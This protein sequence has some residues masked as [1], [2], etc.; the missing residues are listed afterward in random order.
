MPRKAKDISGMRFNHLTALYREENKDSWVC[1]CDCGN[2]THTTLWKLEHDRIKS[3][4]CMQNESKTM[5]LEGNR[6]GRLIVI[7]NQD[8]LNHQNCICKCDCG[9]IK[10][11][12][13][14]SVKNGKT[15]SCGCL[16]SEETSQK[17]TKDLTGQRFGRLVVLD[18]DNSKIGSK[19]TYWNCLCDCGNTV[20]VIAHSLKEGT[21]KSCGCLKSENSSDRFSL[22]IKGEQFGRLTVLERCENYIA[23]NGGQYSQWMCLCSCGT[24]KKIRGHDLVSG[25]VN[26]CGCLISLGEEKVRKSLNSL[27]INYE[28]QYWF[29]NLRSDK[30]RPLKFDFAIIEDSQLKCLIE[31]QGEQHYSEYNH[32]DFGKQQ[33]EVT[34][35]LKRNY[36][37]QNNI[38]LFEIKYDDDVDARI[39]DILNQI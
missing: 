28:T 11:I 26:S 2:I 37:L 3:C 24:I 20:S 4:G 32:G 34:D 25:R 10:S 30:G 13:R 5:Q 18:K 27:K 19:G 29:D 8:D 22:N 36:C 14:Y 12:N 39:S 38:K 23:D 35:I 9:N 7:K 6:Y 31:F 1:E 15:K 21:T 16:H 17:F 33:R